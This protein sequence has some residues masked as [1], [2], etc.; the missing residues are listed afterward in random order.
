MINELLNQS[1]EAGFMDVSLETKKNE[2]EEERKR[3][4]AQNADCFRRLAG[5]SLLYAVIYTICTYKNMQGIAVAVWTVAVVIYIRQVVRLFGSSA[6]LKRGSVFY[7]SVILLLGISTFLTDN[8]YIILMNYMGIFLTIAGLALHNFREDVSWDFGHYLAEMILAVFGAIS[9][10][11]MP[12]VDG[13]AF[14]RQAKGKRSERSRSVLIGI[15]ISIPC[16]F[17]TGMLLVSADLVFENFVFQAFQLIRLPSAVFGIAFTIC[18]GFFSSYCSVR[19]LSGSVPFKASAQR[20]AQPL[21]AIIVCGS[22]AAMYLVF[23]MIQV[24]YLFVGNRELPAGVTYAQYA[25]RGFFQLLLIC[26]VN[27]VIVLCVKKYVSAHKV[28]NGIL[29]LISCCT[30]VMTASSAYRMILYILAYHLTF[31]RVF[32]LVAL[33]TIAIL[34][35]GVIRTVRKPDFPMFRYGMAVVSVI[36]LVFSFSHVDYFIASYNLERIEEENQEN[37]SGDYRYLTGLSTDAAPAIAQYAKE[38]PELLEENQEVLSWYQEYKMLH[39]GQFEE[40]SIRKFNLSHA[41]AGKLL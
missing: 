21:S 5:V 11:G 41:V 7:S 16:L 25:R 1:G 37:R 14:C 3:T 4:D 38:H 35:A 26:V 20:Q 6:G 27:L 17:F 32:V 36:Y 31:L 22:V 30:Y 2:K 10:F 39:R 13:S 8:S 15:L 34:M 12:F 24:L 33:F 9:Y 28:L 23:C 29:L 18:F 40:N 19:Y